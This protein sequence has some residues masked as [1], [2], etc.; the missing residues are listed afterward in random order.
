MCDQCR[1]KLNSSGSKE[2]FACIETQTPAPSRRDLI[3]AGA[4]L[5]AGTAVAQ[6]TPGA[7]QAQGA[8]DAELAR[9]QKAGRIVLKGGI[10]LSL[11]PKVG[12]FASGDVLIEDGKIREVRPN[13]DAAADAAVIVDAT[14]RILI[15]GFVDTHSHSYQGL[16]R[17]SL[18]NGLVDPDYNRDVQNKLTPAY[19]PA[20]CLC[21]RA[22]HGARLHRHG[23][24]RDRRP[25]A[26]QP[27]ARA[28]RRLHRAR[29]Q[30]AGIRAVYGY[31]RGA[32]AAMQWPQDI[33]R[34]AEDLFQLEGPVA[35]AG[36]RREPRR[37]GGGRRARGQRARRHALP[38]QSR[39]GPRA[40]QGRRA[41][42]RAT[43]SSTAR[44]STTRRGG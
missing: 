43:C 32:G 40:G 2:T 41:C 30:D 14:N 22:D 16:L 39:A 6:V 35:D 15:P 5:L 1:R 34:L 44:I 25:L 21:R 11:D 23:H 20:R 7:A 26:D 37:E 29:L 9:L 28:Q 18:P 31:S 4:G 38:R 12:D 10:V 8:A 3:A 36:A 13:I 42:A 17:S 33:A 24:D 27:H 19:T